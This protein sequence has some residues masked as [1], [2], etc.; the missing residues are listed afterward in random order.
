MFG[1]EY[2]IHNRLPED[3]APGSK[4]VKGSKN[5][6]PELDYV[7]F[8]G[9]CCVIKILPKMCTLRATANYVA[10]DKGSKFLRKFVTFLPRY[11]A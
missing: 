9:L 11:A 7:H 10:A 6:N 5:E 8:V 4:H 2:C 3:A 1:T